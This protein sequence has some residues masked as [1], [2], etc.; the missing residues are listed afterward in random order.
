MYESGCDE[1]TCAKMSRVEEDGVR[2]GEVREALDDDGE[3][4]CYVTY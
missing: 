1:D 4:T 2:N 3:C